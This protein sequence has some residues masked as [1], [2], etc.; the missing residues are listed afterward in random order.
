MCPK[1]GLRNAAWLIGTWESKTVRGSLYE[2]WSKGGKDTLTSISYRLKGRDTLLQEIVWLVERHDSLFYVAT[3]FGQNDDQA[4]S[5]ASRTITDSLLVFENPAHDFPQT[6]TYRRVGADSLV[7]A[8]AGKLNGTS[9]E[10][11]FSMKR[12]Q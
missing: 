2:T 12:I 8:I 5:F 3:A 9:Q 4:V 11:T 7:A 1:K 10:R 6:I